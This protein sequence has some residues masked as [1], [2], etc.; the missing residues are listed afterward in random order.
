ME[1]SSS[2]FDVLLYHDITVIAEDETMH[3]KSSAANSL[4]VPRAPEVLREIGA[5]VIVDGMREHLIELQEI[6]FGKV[7]GLGPYN[8]SRPAVVSKPTIAAALRAHRPVDDLLYPYQPV[9][10]PD[11][12]EFLGVKGLAYASP[13][14]RQRSLFLDHDSM[15]PEGII[16]L[17]KSELM[18]TCPYDVKIFHPDAPD[19][20]SDKTHPMITFERAHPSIAA[21]IVYD[22]RLDES[23]SERLGVPV[24][25]TR[26]MKLHNDWSDQEN[27]WRICHIDTPMIAANPSPRHVIMHDLVRDMGGFML[28]GRDFARIAPQH[29]TEPLI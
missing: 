26:A 3:F 5:L 27:G 18:S 19:K 16:R 12:N 23:A 9:R 10:D 22:E 4:E 29:F 1:V 2:A 21:D 24:Y 28:G 6:T 20:V 13:T 15:W 8:P 11:T 25:E 7:V 14:P 17:D